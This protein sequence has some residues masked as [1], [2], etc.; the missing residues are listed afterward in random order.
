MVKKMQAFKKARSTGLGDLDFSAVYEIFKVT[1]PSTWCI[2][3][4]QD[5]EGSE[6]IYAWFKSNIPPVVN[7]EMWCEIYEHSNSIILIPILYSDQLK[8]V[9]DASFSLE[10]KKAKYIILDGECILATFHLT[11][12]PKKFTFICFSL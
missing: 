4:Q 2:F 12:S 10:Q 1:E 7:S 8:Q 9:T 5:Y 11:R 6:V 3:K